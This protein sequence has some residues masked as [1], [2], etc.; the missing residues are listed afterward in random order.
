MEIVVNDTNI[1]IDLYSIGLL[2]QFFELPISV[3]TVDFVINELKEPEQL[4]AVNEFIKNGKLKVQNFD[5]KDLIDI[6]D[7]QSR[8]GGNVSITDC[9]VWHYAKINN[10]T[11]LT[12]DG[13]LRKKAI[14]T[15]VTVK[16]I[17]YVFDYLVETKNT[18]T[19]ISNN[20]DTE[21]IEYQCPITKNNNSRTYRKVEQYITLHFIML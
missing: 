15:N 3:H 17:V 4:K 7:L 20:K 16:G 18:L 10:Y 12:G 11:L 13:Q 6:I 2:E 9:A 14:E 5:T 8:A 1:F 21:S 19:S